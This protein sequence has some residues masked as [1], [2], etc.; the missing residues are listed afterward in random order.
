MSE[1][2]MGIGAVAPTPP[3]GFVTLYP[4][5]DGRM[6]SKSA[7]GVEYAL[8]GV[9]TSDDVPEGATNL[10][11]TIERAQ[12]ALAAAF[13]GSANISFTYNDAGNQITAIVISGSLTDAEINATAAIALTKLASMTA[14]RAVVSD[15]SG[16]LVPSAVS[17]AELGYVQG[18]TS[19]IQTQLNGKQNAGVAISSLTGDVTASGPGSAV[20]TIANSAVT[21]A[22]IAPLAAIALSK[23]ATVTANKALVSDASGFVSPSSAS[24]TEIGHLAGVSSGIQSQLNGK[25]ATGNYVTD[26]TGDVTASGPGSAV[27]TIANNAVTNAKISATAAIA[28]SKLATVSASKALISDASGYLTTNATTSTEIGYLSGV[29]SPIQTQLSGK[30]STPTG[31]TAEY[32]RGDGSVATFPTFS[33]ADRLVT[34]VKNQTGSTIPAGAV[35]YINGSTG[36]D[37]TITP[38]LADS[39]INSA[40]TYGL[41]TAA[42][43]NNTSG[44]VVASGRLQNINTSAFLSGASLYLSPTVAGGYTATKPT[45]PN[46]LVAIGFVIRSHPTQGEI[47]VKVINGFE[48]GELHDVAISASPVTGQSIY[49]DSVTDLWTNQTPP[50]SINGQMAVSFETAVIALT[51][52]ATIAVNAFLG[53][54]F[55]VTLGGNRTLGTPSNPTSGQKIIVRVTQDGTG[56]RTLSYSSGWNL[57]TDF[58]G[59]GLSTSAGATDYVGAIYNS[60]TS[61]WDIVS[62]MRGY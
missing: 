4:K 25:Q 8:T 18:V 2:I 46:H 12:D 29:T 26:L 55:T 20:A 15:G 24:S 57:G 31:T 38:A 39:D 48:L 3:A 35:V 53:N 49:Y 17:S 47:E 32:V 1:H 58:T 21:D 37:P 11:F 56:G 19:S 43:P 5:A 33:Q 13:A 41:T 44:S 28:L 54:T 10:Y 61:K 42:I 36:N 62:I 52:A 27:S 40:K 60:I 59:L 45:A 30:F 6:Y 14:S 51:D 34:T 16:K 50:M 23:L 22:K 9:T 7:A